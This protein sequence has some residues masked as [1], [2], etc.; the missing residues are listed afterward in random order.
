MMSMPSWLSHQPERRDDEA[1]VYID[2]NLDRDFSD[3]KPLRNYHIK[4]DSF[5]FAREKKERQIAL[6]YCGLNVF[7]EEK[8]VSIHFDDG[9]HGTHV[10]G[11][12]AG[13]RIQ[14]QP[15]FNGVAP[16][17]QIISLKI[18]HNAYAGGSTVTGSKKRAFEYAAEYARKHNVPVVCNLSYGIGSEQEGHSDIDRFLD[19]LCQ[20]NPGLI[21]F[22]SAGN[23]G[24]GLSTVGTPA[25]GSAAIS[26]AA[27]LAA[28]SGRDVM[29]LDMDKPEITAL[30]QSRRRIAQ[31]CH[32][33]ARLEHLDCATLE[34]AGRFLGGDQHV[35]A[36]CYRY[37]GCYGVCGPAAISGIQTVQQL[38]QAG[39][40]EQCDNRW[41]NLLRWITARAFRTMGRAVEA[42][43][44]LMQNLQDDI[45]FDYKVSTVSPMTAHGKGPAAYW[46]STWYPADRSQ[47]FT[48]KPRFMPTTDAESKASFSKQLMLKSDAPWCKVRQEQVY[49]R[50]EQSASVRVDYDPSML[51]KPGL[52]V[53]T[54][55]GTAEGQVGFRLVNTVIV[56]YTFNS[57][58]DYRA[59]LKDQQTQG[60]HPLRYFVAV[61]AGASAMHMT[62]R[63]P[64][65]KETEVRA[66]EL[67][68]PNGSVITDY[69]FRLDTH[70]QRTEATWTVT[71]E[72]EP[73][74]WEI[75]AYARRPGETAHYDLD[76]RFSGVQVEPVKI[77][78]WRHAEGS[79]PGGKLALMQLFEDAIPF[80]ATGRIE[81][82]Q[83]TFDQ[84]LS[85]EDTTASKPLKFTP[86][87]QAIRVE[88]EFSE[89]D[90][91]K[92]TDVPVNVF[93]AN[94]TALIQ[95]GMSY[96]TLEVELDNPDPSAES[97][98]CN[99]E[100]MPAFTVES[101]VSATA[102][103][104]VTYLYADPIAISVS[105]GD[106]LYPGIAE[107]LRFELASTPPEAPSGTK[108]VGR[109]NITN[110]G[111]GE[112]VI[113]IPI[114]RG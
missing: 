82:Y 106:T 72:L 107:K 62:M 42:Y 61:P 2:T 78:K 99:L 84:E 27:L 77:T 68:K 31:T 43:Q 45:L 91:A 8:R 37:G 105:G 79:M 74:V 80:R 41:R 71:D 9:G 39:D 54:V 49:F 6:V 19:N 20:E 5:T 89:E 11:I 69:G 81:G 57:Q 70:S 88:V 63:V 85:P 59:A 33:H 23:E 47:V 35:I 60:W 110:T 97:V 24:P 87:I 46:R 22:S 26:V 44:A 66:Y 56:P 112:E 67:F 21:V 48:I 36:V 93:D 17:A 13:Y 98:N 65:G 18:G 40:P 29:G 7:L 38:G 10:A 76:V 15:G 55:T 95:D 109:I 94:G 111:T 64:E 50:S 28:D 83:S 90:F 102:N 100:I 75:C 113:T 32:R 30:Q 58:N 34:Q 96:R 114:E 108:T 16:G 52:Y 25:A 73:G 12:A 4:H 53:A 3:E 14:D 51:T 86:E 92:F 101:D 1:V 103:V 104:K